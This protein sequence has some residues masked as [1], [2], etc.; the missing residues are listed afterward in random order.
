MA[1]VKPWLEIPIQECEEELEDIPSDLFR[2]EP[3][4]YAALGAPYGEGV[5]PFRLRKEIIKRLLWVQSQLKERQPEWRL[6]VFDAWRPLA[7]QG[8]MVQ[9]A[10]ME[11]C[12]RRGINP[13]N[14]EDPEAFAEVERLVQRFWAAPSPNPATPPPH[15]T[16]AAIDLTFA[17]GGGK[18]VEMGGEIDAMGP[19]SFPNYY[20]EGAKKNPGGDEAVWHSR[21]CLLKGLMERQGF[22]QHPNEWWHF[23]FGDQLWAYKTKASIAR[24]ASVSAP[25]AKQS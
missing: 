14:P 13:E 1:V 22:V 21:R 6:A 24:Y 9:H 25:S 20:E 17:D 11:E 18:E 23:S 16:G 10:T 5:H 7:V 19:V 15:S 8:F 4:P 3:H 2:L 12:E